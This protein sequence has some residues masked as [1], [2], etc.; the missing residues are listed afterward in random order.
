VKFSWN[1]ALLATLVAVALLA[2]GCGGIAASPS[3]SPLMF[4]IPGLGQAQPRPV[5]GTLLPPTSEAPDFTLAQ[6]P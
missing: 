2:S 3:I 4:L 6:A 1:Q 5:P